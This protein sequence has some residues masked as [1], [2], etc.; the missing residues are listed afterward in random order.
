ME[1]PEGDQSDTSTAK[2]AYMPCSQGLVP[3]PK[4][5]TPAR[6]EENAKLYDFELTDD[7]IKSLDT[8]EYA[9]VC[10]DPVKSHD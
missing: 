4:S 8:K 1:S 6:I 10:W 3:L 5:V 7:E 9:P 2:N